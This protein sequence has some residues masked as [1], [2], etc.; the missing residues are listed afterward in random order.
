MNRRDEKNADWFAELENRCK[1]KGI[2]IAKLFEQA[3]IDDAAIYKYRAGTVPT[4]KTRVRLEAAYIECEADRPRTKAK[5]CK[6]AK[7]KRR[8]RIC[9]GDEIHC[10]YLRIVEGEI[11]YCPLPRC[12]MQW[13]EEAK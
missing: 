11:G 10:P 9:A 5:K 8:R 2:K 13:G 4:A 7:P 12:A 3:R 6:P 1:S